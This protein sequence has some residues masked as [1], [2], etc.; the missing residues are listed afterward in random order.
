MPTLDIAPSWPKSLRD[1]RFRDAIRGPPAQGRASLPHI[2][3]GKISIGARPLQRAAR[4]DPES[5]SVE[6]SRG[7]IYNADA[8]P[9]VSETDLPG[10]SRIEAVQGRNL[11]EFLGP[12]V[13]DLVSGLVGSLI[14]LDHQRFGVPIDSPNSQDAIVFG[15]DPDVQKRVALVLA[16]DLLNLIP[17]N[18]EH[19][20][21]LVVAFGRW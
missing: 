21:D 17:V 11:L 7:A 16:D 6:I 5:G 8:H 2:R 20:V 9:S 13:I 18:A 14:D 4:P 10:L 15:R 3:G 1:P 12:L 19:G